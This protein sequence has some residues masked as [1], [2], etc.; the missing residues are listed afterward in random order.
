MGK[1]SGIA[2]VKKD[3][4]KSL[5]KTTKKLVENRNTQECPSETVL[6]RFKPPTKGQFSGK[7]KSN[8]YSYKAWIYVRFFRG[9]P[10]IIWTGLNN[11]ISIDQKVHI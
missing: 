8:S 7:Q 9:C 4:T 3:V 10:I 2:F 11:K 1:P 6:Q 5:Q